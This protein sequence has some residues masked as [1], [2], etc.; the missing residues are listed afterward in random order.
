MDF[1]IG[2]KYSTSFL[3]KRTILLPKTFEKDQKVLN[4]I[5]MKIYIQNENRKMARVYT[6]MYTTL[7][8][9]LLKSAV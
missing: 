3:L 1:I 5:N 9:D 6:P 2:L 7:K 8:C 4:W